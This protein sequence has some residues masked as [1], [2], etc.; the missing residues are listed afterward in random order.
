M[1]FTPGGIETRFLSKEALFLCTTIID[2]PNMAIG[3][4]LFL[5]IFVFGDSESDTD[6]SSDEETIVA[7]NCLRQSSPTGGVGEGVLKS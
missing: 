5:L 3:T 2:I 7:S 4:L 6:C 1:F